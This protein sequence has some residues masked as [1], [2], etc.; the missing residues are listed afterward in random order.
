M[1]LADRIELPRLPLRQ[2]RG[3]EPLRRLELDEQRRQDGM[4]LYQ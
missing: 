4:L 1:M 2:R 3:I